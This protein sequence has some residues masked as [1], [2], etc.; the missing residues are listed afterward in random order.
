MKNM[1]LFFMTRTKTIVLIISGV[2]ILFIVLF[3]AHVSPEEVV[4]PEQTLQEQIEATETEKPQYHSDTTPDDCKLCG[5]GSGTILPAYRG[6]NNIGI[7]S[8]NTF[9]ISYVE[10]NPYDDNGEPM[11]KPRKGSASHLLSSGEDGYSSF[12][13][14]NQWRGYADGSVYFRQD[15]FLNME[16][17]ATFLCSDCLNNIMDQCWSDEPYGVGI[18]DFRTGEIRLLEEIVTAFM[19]ND[20]YITCDL[21]E[22][23]EDDSSVEMDLLIFYCPERYQD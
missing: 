18:I 7:I 8:L 4:P 19:F 12:V 22:P 9:T 20:Y 1:K 3:I 6:Q 17:A 13:S 11:K 10:I 21:R 16:K 2:L 14:E 5:K 23:R 15:E